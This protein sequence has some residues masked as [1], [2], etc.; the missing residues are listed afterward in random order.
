ML[1]HTVSQVGADSDDSEDISEVEDNKQQ[2]KDIS[3]TPTVAAGTVGSG[4]TAAGAAVDTTRLEKIKRSMK[5]KLRFESIEEKRERRQLRVLRLEREETGLM[6]D[7]G[8][9]NASLE[10][11]LTT[12]TTELQQRLHTAKEVFSKDMGNLSLTLK[13]F[14][15][16]QQQFVQGL[17]NPFQQFEEICNGIDLSSDMMSYVSAVLTSAGAC[18]LTSAQVTS[19]S[20]IYPLP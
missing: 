2:S 20:S 12:T 16:L 9:A 14:H 4:A 19:H 15:T 10:H 1:F 7:I 11:V 13:R 8:N 18:R 3:S 5:D 17:V 6:E